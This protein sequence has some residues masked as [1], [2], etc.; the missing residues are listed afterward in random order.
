MKKILAVFVAILFAGTTMVALSTSIAMAGPHGHHGHH[1]GHHGFIG[2]WG[3]GPS[4]VVGTGSTVVEE[5]C[6]MVKSCYI[7]KFGEKRCR[8]V[9]DCD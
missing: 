7:N 4:M 6:P 9:R 1:G 8:W 3:V 2:S 5:E